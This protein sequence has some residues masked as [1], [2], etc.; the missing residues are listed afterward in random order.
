MK[1]YQEIA[2]L[3]TAIENCKA[4]KN[5]EWERR[6]EER[7]EWLVR[8]HLPRGGGFDAGTKL[9][10]GSKPDRLAFVTSFHHMNEHGYYTRW[11]THDVIVTPSLAHRFNLR[12]TGPDHRDIKDYIGEV[13]DSA[14]RTEIEIEREKPKLQ[15]V[16][17]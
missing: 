3:L 8:E 5:T 9:T 6:H 2:T 7:L 14:L 10:P 17:P 12:I 11:S 13:F 15:E 16:L 1:L 4:L